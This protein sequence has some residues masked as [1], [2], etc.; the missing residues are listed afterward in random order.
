MTNESFI[1]KMEV[2]L[3]PDHYKF[4]DSY[5]NNT[6][7]GVFRSKDY[8]ISRYMLAI[9]CIQNIQDLKSLVTEI[10]NEVKN[11]YKAIWVIREIGLQI[12]IYGENLLKVNE[13]IPSA[14]TFGNHA[15]IIQGV[16]V[17]DTLNNKVTFDQSQWGKIKFGAATKINEIINKTE[18]I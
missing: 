11:K 9:V 14:D 5:E 12:L 1:K 4:F 18:N 3:I 7:E 8:I 2:A 13:E 15:V 10:R 6:L 17:V 16:H